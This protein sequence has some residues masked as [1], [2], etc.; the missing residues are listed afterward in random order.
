MGGPWRKI[1]ADTRVPCPHPDRPKVARDA[2]NSCYQQWKR[3]VSTYGA[4]VPP[5]TAE[6]R[7][8]DARRIVDSLYATYSPTLISH[9]TAELLGRSMLG[10]R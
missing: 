9:V 4:P 7:A 3:E 10:I 5:L 8:A 1:A 2:C 6:D